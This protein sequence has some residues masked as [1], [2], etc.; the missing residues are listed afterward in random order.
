VRALK[1]LPL[2]AALALASAAPASAQ[3]VDDIDVIASGL[4]NPRHVAVSRDGD[5][6]VAEAG[7][8]EVPANSNSCF[9]SAEGPACTGATGAVT[10]ISRHG[11]RYRQKRIVDGLASFA[12]E[13]G[14][15]AIGPHGIFVSRDDVFVTNGGPTAP[16]RGM[17]PEVVLR[18]PTLVAEEPISALYGRLLELGRHGGFRLIADIWDFERD[19]NPDAEV[20]NPL[21]DS[22]PVDVWADRGRFYV[23]DAGGNTVLRVSRRG[24]VGVLSLFPNVDQPHPFI[25]GAIVPMNAVPTGVVRGPDGFLYVSQLTGFPFPVDGASVFRVDPRTGDYTTYAS[26]FTNAMDLDFGRDGTLYVLEIDSDSLLTDTT[27]DGGIWAVPP[28]GQEPNRIELPA[29]TLTHPGGI[30]VGRRG[31]LFVSNRATA[32]RNGQVLEIELDD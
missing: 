20:G 11:W 28:G 22:N 32:A 12:P 14:N 15:A 4:D 5:V 25:P 29:G 24:E 23:A 1:L 27:T 3:S 21:I 7:R 9:D 6:Y 16:T 2:T 30:A 10:R 8:G 18:D 19:N 13:T 31:D 17:P 26:G